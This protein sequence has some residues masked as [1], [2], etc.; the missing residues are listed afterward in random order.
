MPYQAKWKSKAKHFPET[1]LLLK[2]PCG[3]AICHTLMMQ[4][5]IVAFSFAILTLAAFYSCKRTPCFKA[6]IRF[7]LISFTKAEADTVIIRQYLKA[8]NFTSLKDS[9]LSSIS[10]RQSNDTLEITS[11]SD[12]VNLESGFDYKLFFPG[13]GKLFLLTEIAEEQQE[14]KHAFFSNVKV[15]CENQIVGL[16]VNGAALV[17]QSFNYFYLRK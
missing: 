17:P 3:E 4:K 11:A 15:G 13:A 9:F 10:Y 8:G 6:S 14:I 1:K 7:G 16:K 5:K 12:Y 2:Q